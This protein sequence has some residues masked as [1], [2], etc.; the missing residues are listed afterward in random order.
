MG[1]S[2]LGHSVQGVPFLGGGTDA[3]TGLGF[4]GC[5]MQ[6]GLKQGSWISQN[7]WNVLK[8]GC[9]SKPSGAETVWAWSVH[10][11]FAPVSRW[12]EGWSLVSTDQECSG[13]H[14]LVAA[15]VGLTGLV[16]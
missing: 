4:P 15:L 12:H 11:C 2:I 3:S 8:W 10:R 14:C 7:V 16:W 6:W 9:P 1:R 13:V 5:F